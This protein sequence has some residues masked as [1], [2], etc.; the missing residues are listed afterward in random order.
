MTYHTSITDFVVP[1]SCASTGR[2]SKGK[3]NGD[4]I[5]GMATIYFQTDI[6]TS[7]AWS[8]ACIN[9]FVCGAQ[10]ADTILAVN[11]YAPAT[12]LPPAAALRA[13]PRLNACNCSPPSTQGEGLRSVR[14]ALGDHGR[15]DGQAWAVR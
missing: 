14:T 13:R 11:W 3:G 6:P 15:H 7:A 1:F 10:D 9:C 5:S 2:D 4:T 12:A 8:A